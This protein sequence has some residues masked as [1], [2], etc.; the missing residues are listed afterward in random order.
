MN[1][2][3]VVAGN[4]FEFNEFRSRD[5]YAYDKYMYVN[6]AS[7][8]RGYR[9]PRGTFVGT[10]YKNPNIDEIITQLLIATDDETTKRQL[11]VAKKELDRRRNETYV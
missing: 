3:F 11:Y 4:R 6:D 7:S 2:Y 9:N 5:P 8:I 10:W 1:I